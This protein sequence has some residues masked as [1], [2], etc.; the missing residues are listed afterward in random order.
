MPLPAVLKRPLHRLRGTW[1]DQ[2]VRGRIGAAR[3]TRAARLGAVAAGL[4]APEIAIVECRT[5]PDVS[6]LF[7]EVAAVIGFLDHYERWRRYYAGVRVCFADGL[8]YDPGVGPNWWNCYFEPID[9]GG[10]RG[11]PERIVNPHYHDLCANRVERR[12][13][14]PAA[15]ALVE[16][17]VR[18]QPAVRQQADAFVGAEWRGH[19]IGVHYRGTD[20]WEDA[21]RVEYEK[22]AAVI[23]E[24]MRG[25]PD[26]RIFLAT[27][28]AAFVDYLETTLPGRVASRPMFRSVDG[29]PIDVVNRDGNYQKGLDAVLDCV[30]LS[31]T[32]YLIRTASNLSLCATLFNARL[33][34]TLLNPER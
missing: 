25:K 32:H 17:Y 28:E 18:V 30:L 26:S 29:R 13:P 9:I 21:P 27:D 4:R 3:A 7:S 23:H 22:M 6:G 16:R 12:L 20:K 15:A 33:P 11:A 31:R 10:G 24:A 19:M 34:E 1:R 14:R 2:Q 5:G 8:Y